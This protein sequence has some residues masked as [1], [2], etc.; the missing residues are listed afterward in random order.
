[1][2]QSN[3]SNNMSVEAFDKNARLYAEKYFDLRIYDAFYERL[4]ASVAANGSF[5]DVACGPGNVSAFVKKRRPDLQVIGVDLALNMIAEAR[6]RV[7]DA[8]FEVCDCTQLQMLQKRFDGAAFAFGLSYL[9]DNDAYR[10]LSS[11][12]AVLKQDTPLLLS[13]I[14]GK[15]AMKRTETTSTGDKVDMIYRT[16]EQVKDLMEAHGFRIRFEQLLRSPD[17]AAFQTDDVIILATR[18]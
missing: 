11:L 3:G 9:H 16:P 4:L 14:T 12:H 17:N 2:T 5:I 10:C 15:E 7:P 13:T 8:T 1:M 6:T 18:N